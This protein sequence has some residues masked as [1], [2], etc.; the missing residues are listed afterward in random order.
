VNAVAPGVIQTDMTSALPP[1]K[2][3]KLAA[4]IPMKRTGLPPEV[5]GVMLFLASD[6]S[7]YVTGQVV[8]I[9][10]GMG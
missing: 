9:D 4:E 7:S 10:G 1:E 2:L 6:L 3:R 8:R 5:A